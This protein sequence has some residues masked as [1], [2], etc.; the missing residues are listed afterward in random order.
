MVPVASFLNVLEAHMLRTRLEAED[1]PA[2]VENGNLIYG[3]WSLALAVG[4]ARVCV[5]DNDAEKAR[6]VVRACRAG[7]YYAQLEAEF[8]DLGD[9]ACP[10]CGSKSFT[11]ARSFA[12]IWL[13]LFFVI[14]GAVL[15]A[16]P[17]LHRC[18]ACNNQWADSSLLSLRPTA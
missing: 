10:A 14:F 7:E 13:A 6:S 15:Q 2:F 3:K 12:D 9:P 8:G 4:G 17:R 11:S 18:D 1:I 16:R 5:I